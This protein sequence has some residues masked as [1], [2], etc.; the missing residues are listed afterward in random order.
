MKKVLSP[1][2]HYFRTLDRVVHGVFSDDLDSNYKDLLLEFELAYRDLGFETIQ[3]KAHIL[4]RHVGQYVQATGR[5][6]GLFSEQT[7][8]ASHAL[9]SQYWSKYSIRDPKHP[10]YSSNLIKSTLSRKIKQRFSQFI[11]T[12]VF[13]IQ[14]LL[15][16]NDRAFRYTPLYN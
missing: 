7:M 11:Q 1:Y 12:I 9:F 2:L 3:P 8:E 14:A 15:L 16:L 5:G 4:A 13:A 6:L 10:N